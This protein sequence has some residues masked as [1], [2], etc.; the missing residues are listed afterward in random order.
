MSCFA[1]IERIPAPYLDGAERLD[2]LATA[3]ITAGRY[4]E[5]VPVL[6]NAMGIRAGSSALHGKLATCYVRICD[7]AAGRAEL[8]KLRRLLP[9]ISAQQYVDCYPCAFDSFKDA[10]ANSLAEIGMPA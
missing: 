8:E 9:G 10:L 1:R 3:H 5:A 6:R 7:K 2:G 4:A